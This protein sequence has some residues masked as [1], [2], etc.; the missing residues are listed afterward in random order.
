MGAGGN[1]VADASL[2]DRALRILAFEARAWPDADTKSEAI[3]HELGLSGARYYRLLGG[4]I[5]QP[6]ALRH[7]PLLVNRLLRLRDARV[8]ARAHRAPTP[9]RALD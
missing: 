5:E 3:R 1:G 2:D 6:A 4:I 7:D 8:A 9:G